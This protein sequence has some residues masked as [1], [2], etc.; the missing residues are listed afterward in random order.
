MQRLL[1]DSYCSCFHGNV[2]A[3]YV[4]THIVSHVTSLLQF[5]NGLRAFNVTWRLDLDPGPL[6]SASST[7]NR[8]VSLP[9]PI[10][11]SD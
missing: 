1:A 9:T 3:D 2:L 6:V 4:I 10:H 5:R 11:C 7:I 8:Q